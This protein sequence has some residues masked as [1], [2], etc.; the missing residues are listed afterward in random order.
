MKVNSVLC[1]HRDVYKVQDKLTW[2]VPNPVTKLL[3]EK[4]DT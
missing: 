3:M 2:R 1:Y 4:F